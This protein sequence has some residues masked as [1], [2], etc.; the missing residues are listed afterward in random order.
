VKQD[1][2]GL[3]VILFKVHYE[4]EG[5]V[6]YLKSAFSLIRQLGSQERLPFVKGLPHPKVI[7]SHD[8]AEA[9]GAF[10]QRRGDPEGS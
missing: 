7:R 8:S 10:P 2:L 3:R 9:S 6:T 4:F 1:V 5:I